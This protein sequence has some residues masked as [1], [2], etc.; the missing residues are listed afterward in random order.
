MPYK[1]L[2]LLFFVCFGATTVMANS[3]DIVDLVIQKSELQ[4]SAIGPRYSEK[5]EVIALAKKM[6]FTD[7][8]ETNNGRT[9]ILSAAHNLNRV[10]SFDYDTK[11]SLIAED[12]F[13]VVNTNTAYSGPDRFVRAKPAEGALSNRSLF[14]FYRNYFSYNKSQDTFYSV[15]S[16]SSCGYGSCSTSFQVF[17]CK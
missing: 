12:V 15:T 2:S 10:F 3:V 5:E 6:G 7:L 13:E 4:C 1:F 11:I 16:T 9:K 17:S 8:L 14:R